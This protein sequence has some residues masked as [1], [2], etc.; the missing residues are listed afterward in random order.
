MS[1]SNTSLYPKQTPIEPDP[2]QFVQ[3]SKY[4]AAIPLDDGDYGIYDAEEE[5]ARADL[6]SLP[7]QIVLD[8]VE[9]EKLRDLLPKEVPN[10]QATSS[11]VAKTGEKRPREEINTQAAEQVLI[12]DADDEHTM[13]PRIE[14]PDSDT[15]EV[16]T[17]PTKK[18]KTDAG[19]N[20]F[21]TEAIQNVSQAFTST[22]NAPD[23]L[24]AQPPMRH[25]SKSLRHQVIEKV[26]ETPDGGTDVVHLVTQ[27]TNGEETA[28][29]QNFAP[30]I[31]AEVNRLDAE[32]YEKKS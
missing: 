24:P 7:P 14:D 30:E 3:R 2:L 20:A 4:F 1:V 12:L 21:A 17:P 25:L 5:S 31:V 9:R 18:Q 22:L 28:E 10:S 13:Q 6:N 27:V 8:I 23:V 19:V 16:P 26:I 15:E 29:L 32:Y 11:P